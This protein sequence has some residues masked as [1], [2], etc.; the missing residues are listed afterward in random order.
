MVEGEELLACLI[1][2][3]RAQVQDFVTRSRHIE[4]AVRYLQMERSLEMDS[5][6]SFV[7]YDLR[8]FERRKISL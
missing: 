6:I 1:C 3:G 7:T 5:L 8:N 2:Y 4:D